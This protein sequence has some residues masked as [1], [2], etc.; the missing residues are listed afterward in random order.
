[1]NKGDESLAKQIAWW[2]RKHEFTEF[3]SAR[4]IGVTDRERLSYWVGRRDGI[5]MALTVTSISALL[6]YVILSL[7]Q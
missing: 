2:E 4:D 7:F 3:S 1:M 5:I 6:V